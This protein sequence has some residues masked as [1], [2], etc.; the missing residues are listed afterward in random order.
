MPYYSQKHTDTTGT[1]LSGENNMA[2]YDPKTRQTVTLP[3]S[4]GGI[5]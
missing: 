3:G 5:K 1:V 2:Y 4:L